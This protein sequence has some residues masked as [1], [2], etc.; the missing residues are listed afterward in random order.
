MLKF[1]LTAATAMLAGCAFAPAGTITETVGNYNHAVEKAKNEMFLLNVVRASERRPMHFT[2]I[3]GLRGNI[4]TVVSSGS[5]PIPFGGGDHTSVYSNGPSINYTANPSFDV[6]V[7]DSKAFWLGITTPVPASTLRYYLE[8][9][10]PNELVLFLFIRKLEIF[11]FQFTNYPGKALP[12]EWAKPDANEVASSVPVEAATGGAAELAKREAAKRSK[13]DEDGMKAF[14]IV[15]RGLFGCKDRDEDKD[16]D[17]NAGSSWHCDVSFE[18]EKADTYGAPVKGNEL[19]RLRDLVAVEKED[20][21]LVEDKCKAGQYR[22]TKKSKSIHIAG[23]FPASDISS[24]LDAAEQQLCAADSALKKKPDEQANAKSAASALR[25]AAKGLGTALQQLC[26]TRRNVQASVYRYKD[27]LTHLQ[28]VVRD[29]NIETKDVAD[30]L[31]KWTKIVIERRDQA[32]KDLDQLKACEKEDPSKEIIDSVAGENMDFEDLK[33]KLTELDGQR[34]EFSRKID[35]L[36][37]YCVG[38]SSSSSCDAKAYF[39]SPEAILYYLGEVVR[40]GPPEIAVQYCAK[41]REPQSLFEVHTNSGHEKHP[42]VAVEFEGNH[43]SIDRD[44]A[45]DSCSRTMT[46]ETLT[47]V[48]QLFAQQTEAAQAP[49]TGAVTIVGPIPGR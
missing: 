5:L 48:S 2:Y 7:Q 47:L 36:S 4:Q 10:W 39:R 12:A 31:E 46:T 42:V 22:L 33:K 24:A 40:H 15:L 21:K 43:Y 16:E 26:K 29:A 37:S 20:L 19:E 41:P 30:T 6:A 45:K 3:S 8:Q 27:G 35:R 34:Q 18:D 32:N 14:R 28:R 44:A 25:Q 17:E 11:G 38:T 1:A 13:R 9:G 49:A 23:L